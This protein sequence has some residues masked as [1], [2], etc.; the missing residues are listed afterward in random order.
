MCMYV[1][2]VVFIFI[3]KDIIANKIIPLS[4]KRYLK[5]IRNTKTKWYNQTAF[6]GDEFTNPTNFFFLNKNSKLNSLSSLTCSD[7]ML[8]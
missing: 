7:G 6:F 3:I 1:I 2:N 4:F 5:Y 8:W